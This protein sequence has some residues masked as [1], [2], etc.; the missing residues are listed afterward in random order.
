[1]SQA[2]RPA[3]PVPP[4][5]NL[6]APPASEPATMLRESGAGF[7]PAGEVAG[8]NPG[9]PPAGPRT[10][11]GFVAFC[12]RR[13]EGSRPLPALDKARGEIRDGALVLTSPHNFLCDRLKASLPVLTELARAYFGPGCAVRVEAPVEEIRKPL[14]ELREMALADPAVREAQERFQA[15]IVE[16]RAQSNGNSKE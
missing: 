4:A 15:R 8:A 14:A 10:W 6:S 1:M 3:A 13:P 5:Q 16:V 7:G 11:N 2:P 9:P 12:G